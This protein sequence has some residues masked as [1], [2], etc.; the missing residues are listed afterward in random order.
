MEEDWRDELPNIAVKKTDDPSRPKFVSK[1]EREL[2]KTKQAENEKAKEE[3]EMRKV[4]EEKKKFLEGGPQR[5]R[6]RS[7]EK[8][9][10]S[11]GTYKVVNNDQSAYFPQKEKKKLPRPDRGHAVFNFEWDNGEDTSDA[12]YLQASQYTPLFGKGIV[13]GMDID[14]QNIKT[15][16]TTDHASANGKRHVS[17]FSIGANSK[18]WRD[19]ARDEMTDRDWKIF[20]E[21]MDIR[22]VS[23]KPVVPMRNWEDSN[24]DNEIQ[25]KMYRLGFKVPTP[26][27]MQAIPTG[28]AR[29]DL[30]ALAPT[31]SGKTLAFLLPVLQYLLPLRP[32]TRSAPDEGPHAVVLSPTRELALQI[33][34]VFDTI[35]QGL[36]LYS[37]ALIGGHDSDDQ[38]NLI[39]RGVDVI[40]GTPGRVRDLLD[41]ALI[42]LERCHYVVI[43]EA[44]L[45]IDLGLETD[46]HEIL[47]TIPRSNLKSTVPELAAEQEVQAARRHAPFRTTHMFSATMPPVLKSIASKYLRHELFISIG[48]PGEGNKNIKHELVLTNDA[49]KRTQLIRWVDTSSNQTIIFCNRQEEVDNVGKYLSA[50]N[51]SVAVYHGGKSQSERESLIDRFKKNKFKILVST[52]LAGRGLD[53]E[54]IRLVINY[55]CPKTIETYVHR[56][57]RTGRAGKQGTA[58]TFLTSADEGIFYDLVT[59]MRTNHQTIPAELENHPLANVRQRPEKTEEEKGQ[60]APTQFEGGLVRASGHFG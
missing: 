59:Y 18:N 27:Q 44:D 3:E 20:R 1:A 22:I 34:Q 49:S 57:G 38:E 35:S 47:S 8:Q 7:K 43:D 23:G 53:V 46:L 33:Q 29:K 58:V 24:L 11:D 48:E 19:K 15:S 39:N 14:A 16:Q 50:E 56:A 31:G 17:R 21:D 52:D 26:V 5:E 6:S 60:V 2:L 30:V 36:E 51:Y 10:G 28:I 54:G 41:K 13:G 32:Q 12:A 37:A 25:K 4:L 40:F 45:M 42:V 9:R 55:D